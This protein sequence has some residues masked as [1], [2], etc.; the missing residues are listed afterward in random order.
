MFLCCSDE[1][2]STTYY[3][4]LYPS[5]VRTYSLSHACMHAIILPIDPPPVL[6]LF[7]LPL[8]GFLVTGLGRLGNSLALLANL[9]PRPCLQNHLA[10]LVDGGFPIHSLCPVFLCRNGKD[11]LLGNLVGLL[12]LE[13][14]LDLGGHPGLALEKVQAELDLGAQLV[15]VLS[16]RSGGTNETNVQAVFGNVDFFGDGPHGS[17]IFDVVVVVVVG[18][19]FL[20]LFGVVGNIFP[21]R[22]SLFVFVVG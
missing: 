12:F 16:T 17:S 18:W 14:S 10:Q 13:A 19:L 3:Y 20:G 9:G 7:A 11:S 21:S 1:M 5:N 4:I 8:F 6:F 2:E 22:D 15:D